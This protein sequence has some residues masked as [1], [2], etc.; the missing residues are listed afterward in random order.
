MNNDDLDRLNEDIRSLKNRIELLLDDMDR[1]Y[2]NRSLDDN[3]FDQLAERFQV[4]IKEFE[5]LCRSHPDFAEEKLQKRKRQFFNDFTANISPRSYEILKECFTISNWEFEALAYRLIERGERA[6]LERVRSDFPILFN[7]YLERYKSGNLTVS[8]NAFSH[9]NFIEFA[10]KNGLDV[11]KV[12]PSIRNPIENASY[13]SDE[14]VIAIDQEI[15]NLSPE[16]IVQVFLLCSS[17]GKAAFIERALFHHGKI[18]Q[19]RALIK[20]VLKVEYKPTHYSG[21]DKQKVADYSILLENFEYD[22]D[23]LKRPFNCLRYAIEMSPSLESE[24]W[25]MNG[26]ISLMGS[27][28]DLGYSEDISK[29]VDDFGNEDI[30]AAKNKMLMERSMGSEIKTVKKRSTI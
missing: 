21:L 26:I 9:R 15:K 1:K 6:T 18:P 17:K 19:I 28:I 29:M 20:D 5:A 10:I 14:N 4:L 2:F 16:K 22:E 13:L 27:F 8:E 30:R 7:D 11:K 25:L 23:C 24:P 12:V 3:Q